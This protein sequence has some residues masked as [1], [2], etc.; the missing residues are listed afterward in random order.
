MINSGKQLVVVFISPQQQSG[1]FGNPRYVETIVCFYV[2]SANVL[3]TGQG[4]HLTP[5]TGLLVPGIHV[6]G[7]YM[8]VLQRMFHV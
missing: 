6:S 1:L 2:E 4:P 7:M 8:R 3:R 5:F